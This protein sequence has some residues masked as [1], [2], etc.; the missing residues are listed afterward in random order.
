MKKVES[1]TLSGLLSVA[2]D[3][4]V[5]VIGGGYDTPKYLSCEDDLR[6]KNPENGRSVYLVPC[7]STYGDYTSVSYRVDSDMDGEYKQGMAYSDIRVAILELVKA[8][9]A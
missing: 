8:I 5:S 1:T 4:I 3:E 6:I 2:L 9:R 7:F